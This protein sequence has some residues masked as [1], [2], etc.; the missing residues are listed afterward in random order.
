MA[1]YYSFSTLDHLGGEWVGIMPSD[2]PP[3]ARS[4]EKELS[5]RPW[6]EN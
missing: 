5:P 4:P 6:G 1:G 3:P 2:E